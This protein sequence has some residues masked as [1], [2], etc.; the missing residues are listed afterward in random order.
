MVAININPFTGP[1]EYETDAEEEGIS[2]VMTGAAE[3]CEGDSF[4]GA[5]CADVPGL[6]KIKVLETNLHQLDVSE[7]GERKDGTIKLEMTCGKLLDFSD[8]TKDHYL[9]LSQS[10]LTLNVVDCTAGM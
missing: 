2:V 1:G 9:G 5:G 3:R 10:A 6:C 7:A 8:G 4:D